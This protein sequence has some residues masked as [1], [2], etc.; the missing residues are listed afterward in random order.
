ME[1]AYKVKSF[2]IFGFVLGSTSLHSQDYRSSPNNYQNSSNNYEN[3][4]EN[5][6]NS[7]NNYDNSPKKY[8]ND[9]IIRDNHG[10]PQAYAVPKNDGGVN[11]FDMNG[12][13]IGY[14]PAQ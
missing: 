5:Y 4:S 12:N 14:L 3:R 2:L 8:G 6:N 1:Y 13:R 11:F 7:P 10:N 9:R